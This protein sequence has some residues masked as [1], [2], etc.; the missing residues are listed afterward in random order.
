MDRLIGQY[1]KIVTK[2][3]GHEKA[4]VAIGIVKDIDH[5][6]GF[7]ILE[8]AQGVGCL[9]IETITAIKPNSKKK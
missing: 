2:E 8:S 9:N 1:C 5:E 3:P 4:H 6:A 7:L